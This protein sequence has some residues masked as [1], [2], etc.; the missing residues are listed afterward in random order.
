MD[1]FGLH[2]ALELDGRKFIVHTGTLMERQLVISEIFEEGL[3]L[4]ARELYL[5]L[6]RENHPVNYDFIT[7]ITNQFHDQVIE[8]LKVLYRIQQKLEKVFAAKKK[9]EDAKPYVNLGT[10]FLRRNLYDE[11]ER[12]FQRAVTI[13]RDNIKANVGLGVTYLKM[14][15]FENAIKVLQKILSENQRFPDVLNYLGLAHLFAG[16]LERAA[17]LFKEAIQI[18]PEYVEAQFNLGVALYK[19]ALQ[20]VKDPRAVAVPARVSI[21]LK[22]VRDLEKYRDPEWEKEFS[23]V[24]ELMKDNDHEV[25]L[26]LL[27]RLQLKLV[28]VFVKNEK[29]AEFFLKF[30]YG[31]KALDVKMISRYDIFFMNSG[32]RERQYPDY[33]NNRGVFQLIKSHAYFQEAIHAFKNALNLE[34]GYQEAQETLDKLKAHEKGFIFMIRAMLK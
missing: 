18:N 27:E 25:I 10:L 21:Y 26:P 24:L 29:V 9:Q 32:T 3:F 23:E 8:E 2:T 11:A 12:A 14:R 6:R 28:D 31:G 17:N 22:Q 1:D 16:N 20:G 15:R 33:W 7:G 13:Q 5:P 30:Q 19:S 34:P 4:T